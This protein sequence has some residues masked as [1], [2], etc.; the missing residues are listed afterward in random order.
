MAVISHVILHVDLAA[1]LT[2]VAVA[3]GGDV[4]YV[5]VVVVIVLATFVAFAGLIP[6]G[7]YPLGSCDFAW[8]LS[9]FS[10]DF[11]WILPGFCLDFAWILPGFCLDFTW[12]CLD[13]V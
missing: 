2:V 4:A 6:C 9:G 5:V 11:A 7:F 10:L 1:L 8:I 12:F 3:T 13:L